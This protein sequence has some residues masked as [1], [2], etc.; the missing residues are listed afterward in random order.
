MQCSTGNSE[1]LTFRVQMERNGTHQ[2]HTLSAN[3]GPPAYDLWRN[4][5]KATKTKTHAQS[6]GGGGGGKTFLTI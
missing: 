6:L 3:I 4:P 2:T 1:I 5:G